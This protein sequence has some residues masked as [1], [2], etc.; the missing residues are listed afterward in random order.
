MLQRDKGMQTQVYM[1]PVATM[2]YP[3][4][5]LQCIQEVP[6]IALQWGNGGSNL[7]DL[8]AYGRPRVKWFGLISRKTPKL[9]GFMHTSQCTQV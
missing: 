3:F 7:S 9:F 8:K 1:Q 2:D 5:A 4:I 6:Y